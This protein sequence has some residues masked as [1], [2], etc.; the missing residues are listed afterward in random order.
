MLLVLC[1]VCEVVGASP[2]TF[3][4][5]AKDY[6]IKK[7]FRHALYLVTV[8]LHHQNQVALA[9]RTEFLVSEIKFP[10]TFHTALVITQT[11]YFHL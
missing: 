9:L 11:F 6:A 10:N 3:L 1:T 4:K 2:Q 5:L 8:H 7:S